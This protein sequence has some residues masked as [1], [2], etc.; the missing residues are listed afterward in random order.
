MKIPF[1]TQSIVSEPTKELVKQLDTDSTR[2]D[3]WLVMDGDEVP[4]HYMAEIF[5]PVCYSNKCYP[6]FINFYWDLLG[7]FDRYEMP[8]GK[9][10]TKLDHLPFEPEDYEKILRILRNKASLL[11]DY[12]VEELVVSTETS[13][14]NGI[15]AITGATSKTIQ[16]E[17]ISGAVYSC[18]TLWHLAHGEITQSIRS[19]TETKVTDSML[20][21]FLQSSNHY[22]QYFAMDRLLETNRAFQSPFL[23]SYWA[24]LESKNLFVAEYALARIPP[25]ELEIPERQGKVL[26]IY[27]RSPYRL[28]LKLLDRLQEVKLD[29]RW[30]EEL[31]GH[32]VTANPEQKRRIFAVVERQPS[33][34][35]GTLSKLS[36]L[37]AGTEF[38]QR[39]QALKGDQ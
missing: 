29:P 17:V 13:Y 7:N 25:E 31:I 34:S 1:G 8:E 2:Y 20:T 4:D 33:L 27:E 16:S 12:K 14:T 38:E 9:I 5:T 10:L 37:L 22:Y 6:V 30:T 11:K 35:S 3:L 36:K 23:E 15:D 24:V 28:Q 19:Y 18:Y 26:H 39:V 32:L 21:D